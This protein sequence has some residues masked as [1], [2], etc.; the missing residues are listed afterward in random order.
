MLPF[1]NNKCLSYH[2]NPFLLV[3]MY[4]KNR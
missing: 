3:F 1:F 2:E 4:R